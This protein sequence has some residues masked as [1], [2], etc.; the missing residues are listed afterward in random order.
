LWNGTCFVPPIWSPFS[1]I[2]HRQQNEIPPNRFPLLALNTHQAWTK[3]AAICPVHLV[4]PTPNCAAYIPVLILPRRSCSMRIQGMPLRIRRWAWAGSSC[5]SSS[6]VAAMVKASAT[7]DRLN[8]PCRHHPATLIST[9][10]SNPLFFFHSLV[11]RHASTSKLMPHFTVVLVISTSFAPARTKP[12]LSWTIVSPR[13][14]H[15]FNGLVWDWSA[16]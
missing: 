16:S 12:L 2:S 7:A 4:K 8:H 13:P 14:Q 11:R 10:Y 1:W 5:M 9:S 15:K 6:E 3:S